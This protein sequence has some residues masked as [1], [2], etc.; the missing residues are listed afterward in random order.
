MRHFLLTASFCLGE[1]VGGFGRPP[2]TATEGAETPVFWYNL[3]HGLRTGFRTVT[4]RGHGSRCP[5][6]G[7]GGQWLQRVRV[8]GWGRTALLRAGLPAGVG[9][10]AFCVCL[11]PTTLG[12]A[13]QYP[14]Y[15]VEY[16][17]YPVEYPYCPVGY[18]TWRCCEL[19]SG[20][21]PG[22]T[23][24]QAAYPKIGAL[25]SGIECCTPE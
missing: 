3:V 7:C 20:E 13:V 11:A 23:V 12:G 16:P 9:A 1:G 2:C 22:K 24:P 6:V 15:P 25:S 19:R 14:C 17:H 5:S 21:N 4:W 10:P 18:P 8:W